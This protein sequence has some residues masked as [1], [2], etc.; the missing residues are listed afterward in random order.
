MKHYG[1][2]LAEGSVIT[3]I[4]LPQ[5]TTFPLNPNTGEMVFRTDLDE[6]YIYDNGG[7]VVVPTKIV[8]GGAF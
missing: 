1:L 2:T 3:N 5:G 7:W 6:L 8:D 4:T